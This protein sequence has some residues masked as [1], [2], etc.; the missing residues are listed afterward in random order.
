MALREQLKFEFLGSDI[1]EACSQ[2]VR[3]HKERLEWWTN[4]QEEAKAALKDA[5]VEFEEYEYTNGVEL[6]VGIDQAKKAR[7]DRCR[8]KIDAHRTNLEAYERWYRAFTVNPNYTFQLDWQ[9]VTYFG[10]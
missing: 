6:R 8:G 5:A 3:Y 4:E 9:D 10:L 1:A 7:Y 2:K